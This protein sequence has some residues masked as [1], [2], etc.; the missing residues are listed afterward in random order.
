MGVSENFWLWESYVL[1]MFANT[2]KVVALSKEHTVGI[3]F[4]WNE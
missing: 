3:A 1:E 4:M 2:A